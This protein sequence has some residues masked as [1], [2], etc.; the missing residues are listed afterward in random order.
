MISC[1]IFRFFRLS[2]P[3]IGWQKGRQKKQKLPKN[4][5]FSTSATENV[6][7]KDAYTYHNYRTLCDLLSYEIP[8]NCPNGPSDILFKPCDVVF[9]LNFWRGAKCCFVLLNRY[10]GIVTV[11]GFLHERAKGYA[12]TIEN[13]RRTTSPCPPLDNLGVPDPHPPP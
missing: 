6:C 12:P 7:L 5:K 9:K 8:L 3:P 1:W 10:W 13:R 4:E 2:R 11:P